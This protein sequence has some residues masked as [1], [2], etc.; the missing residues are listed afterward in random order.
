MRYALESFLKLCAR[1]GPSR[2]EI[3]RRS[4]GKAPTKP[5]QPGTIMGF[6]VR[7]ALLGDLENLETSAI[8]SNVLPP[9]CFSTAA[10]NRPL[11]RSSSRARAHDTCA[12]A[13]AAVA[14]TFKGL[15]TLRARQG[16]SPTE[17]PQRQRE[18]PKT[19]GATADHRGLRP[20][21]SSQG[22]GVRIRVPITA[23]APSALRLGRPSPSVCKL[24]V[25]DL[26]TV[27][28]PGGPGR[29]ACPASRV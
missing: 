16:P 4:A 21:F 15:D 19:A 10:C 27:K 2:P 29:G 25:S 28:R 6:A 23:F 8:G 12:G 18:I 13:S 20:R 17:T 24:S 5:T 22:T 1:N 26:T 3:T 14:M 9:S 11:P 7:E